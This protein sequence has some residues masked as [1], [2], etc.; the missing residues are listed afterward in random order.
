MLEKKSFIKGRFK[1]INYAFK[2][3]FILLKN[4][5][6]IQAQFIFFIISVILGFYFSISSTEWIFQ[7]FGF[8]LIFTAEGLNTA[9]E[10]IANFIHPDYHKKIGKIKDISAGAVTFA[11]LTTIAIICIIYMPKF[12]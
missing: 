9:I 4:E 3:F 1:S 5:H 12:I 11:A 6:S 7:I 2:G 10:E 8:G